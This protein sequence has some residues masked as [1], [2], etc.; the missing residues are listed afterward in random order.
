MKKFRILFET[1][2]QDKLRL[3]M[4]ADPLIYSDVS[5]VVPNSEI[6]DEDWYEVISENDDPWDQYWALRQ[7]AGE[8]QHFVRNVRVELLVMEPEWRTIG[9][10]EAIRLAAGGGS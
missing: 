5:Q 7:W 9:P 2:Y 10:D 6:P 1:V 8:D 3:Y 4:D